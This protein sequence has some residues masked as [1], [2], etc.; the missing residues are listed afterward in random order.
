MRNFW[1]I[2]LN[3][4]VFLPTFHFYDLKNSPYDSQALMLI[5]CNINL[6][7]QATVAH[8]NMIT[9]MVDASG[10]ALSGTC[11]VMRCEVLVW[12][13]GVVSGT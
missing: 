3:Y 4:V 12:S 1:N 9:R 13:C 2:R 6:L 7:W 8:F 5:A 10:H 11:V